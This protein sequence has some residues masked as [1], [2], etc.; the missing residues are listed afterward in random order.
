M[1]DWIVVN[2]INMTFQIHFIT[3]VFPKTPL[4]NT[5]L[6]RSESLSPLGI[7]AENLDLIVYQRLEKSL[8]LAERIQ[9]Q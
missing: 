8:S 1:F 4:P 5:P 6:R 7:L 9:M 2:I 3:Y